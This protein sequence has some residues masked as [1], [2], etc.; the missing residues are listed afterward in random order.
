VAIPASDRGRLESPKYVFE[1][2]NLRDEL[3]ADHKSKAAFLSNV[4]LEIQTPLNAVLGI[5]KLLN[6]TNLDPTQKRY[7][8]TIARSS[9][10]LLGVLSNLLEYSQLEAGTV[11]LHAQPL[12]VA[13]LVSESLASVEIP[14]KAKGIK[15]LAEIGDGSLGIRL[16]DRERIGQILNHLVNNAIKFTQSGS[17]SVSVERLGGHQDGLFSFT[18]SDTGIGMSQAELEA[19]M[20]G[21]AYD[22]SSGIGLGLVISQR[23][24]RLMGGRIVATSELGRG[25]RFSLELPMGP[26]L[27]DS[28]QIL[29]TGS[30][31]LAGVRVLVVEDHSIE[32]MVLS[33]ILLRYGAE[34]KV[35]SNATSA[36]AAIC[37]EPF[38]VILIDLQRSLM[39][40]IR[41]SLVARDQG[42]Y[43][44][45]APVIGVADTLSEID[46][47]ACS[48]AGIKD[49][50]PTPLD[51]REL[52]ET[53][54]RL[55]PDRVRRPLT[56]GRPA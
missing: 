22:R 53:L 18:V 52:I 13:N 51:E 39:D 56:L 47:W 54:L 9:E 35:S 14:A 4:A 37:D 36:I 38:D 34:A 7:A 6:A 42:A 1:T 30:R 19:V 43:G 44:H 49:V 28:D 11:T 10:G 23:L 20:Q 33:S 25:S 12:H 29:I 15:L 46:R 24:A 32:S 45:Q 50:I 17:V 55:V 3:L 8:E 41:A 2:S 48:Q 21:I 5:A 31:D 16:G 27:T 40:G 26:D